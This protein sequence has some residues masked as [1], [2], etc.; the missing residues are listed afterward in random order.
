ML[1]SLDYFYTCDDSNFLYPRNSQSLKL[2]S[3][4]VCQL[5]LLMTLTF[6]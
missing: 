3:F 2:V 6:L 4:M 5:E 1:N